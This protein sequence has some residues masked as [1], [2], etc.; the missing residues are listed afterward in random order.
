MDELDVRITI[1]PAK[2]GDPA[3]LRAQVDGDASTKSG[4]SLA[5]NAHR[6][7]ASGKPPSTGMIWPVVQRERG[8]AR[9]KMAS[10]QSAGS[11]G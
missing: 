4:G 5:R 1:A 2:E 10:A 8:L 11:I 6:K 9:N 3:A 7:N